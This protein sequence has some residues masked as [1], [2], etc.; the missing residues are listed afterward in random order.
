MIIRSAQALPPAAFRQNTHAPKTAG[1]P[2]PMP[3]KDADKVSISSEAAQMAAES[4]Y[5][6]D[7]AP[8][9][10]SSMNLTTYKMPDALVK[11]MEVRANEEAVRAGISAQYA[12]ANRYETVGQILVDGKLVADV[13]EAGGYGFI[14][15]GISSLSEATLDP[16]ARLEEIARALQDKDTGK[17]EVRY[18][19]FLPGLGGVAGPAAPESLLPAF[20]ARDVRDIFREA[21]DAARRAAQSGT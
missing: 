1:A 16:H 17:V 8:T 21:I 10:L 9:L 12:Q 15:G 20:T 13:D 14:G 3:G 19:N 7:G 2:D 5:R 18:A 6:V 11:E 4:L